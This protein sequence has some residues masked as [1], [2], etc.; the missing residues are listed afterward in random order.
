VIDLHQGQ[1]QSWKTRPG[2]QAALLGSEATRAREALLRDTAWTRAIARRGIIDPSDVYVMVMAS[3]DSD[4]SAARRI[5]LLPF[6][7]GDSRNR[8]A[9]PVEGLMAVFD[10]N[11]GVVERIVDRGTAPLARSADLDT[12]TIASTRPLLAPLVISQPEGSSASIRG[13]QVRWDRWRFR[14]TPH[15]RDGLVLHLVEHDDGARV[16][17]IIYRAS[18]SEMLVP[19]A[20]GDSTWYFRA[21][22]DVG[23]YML[24]LTAR[25]LVEG[26]DAPDNSLYIDA[27]FAREGKAVR[28]PRAVA[29]YE[30]D[31]GVIWRHGAEVR[32]GRQLVVRSTY[33]V[34]N[35]DYG[36]NWIFHQD[37]SLQLE[38]ELT[39]VMFAMGVPDSDHEGADSDGEHAGHPVAPRLVAVHHQH[40][41]SFRLDMDVDGPRNSVI[42]TN[43][44][45]IPVGPANPHGNAFAIEQR[46]F[47]SERSAARDASMAASR[48]WTVINPA[49]RNTLGG[50]TGYVLV[51]GEVAVPYL[52][53]SAAARKR[54][55]FVEHQ[56]WVTRAKPDEIYAAGDYPNQGAAGEGLPRW[57]ADDEAIDSSDVVVW[58]TLGLTHVPRPEEW[59]VM[60]VTRAGFMLRPSG[61]FSANPALD[62]RIRSAK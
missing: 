1:V 21:A 52:A 37:G 33:T 58:H 41:F 60:P 42:E 26:L 57:I 9:R 30:R 32:R 54:A 6:F 49:V 43:A 59:P 47:T 10:A 3:G 48:T 16:R 55:G 8:Y 56:F 13:N 27:V 23:E 50:P 53:R 24:G 18:L 61:F 29:I 4:P 39:G 38:V 28:V 46:L 17:P 12:V 51:P 14:F 36:L 5:R 31:G 15:P 44:R 20:S 22:M 7:R 25:S 11:R 62:V 19:Y 35:Y 45:A 2:V 40:F 34:G